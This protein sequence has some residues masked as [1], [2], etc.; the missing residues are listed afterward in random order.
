MRCSWAGDEW[1]DGLDGRRVRGWDGFRRFLLKT[2]CWRRLSLK[3]EAW[4]STPGR[5][6]DDR[7]LADPRILRSAVPGILK[8]AFVVRRTLGINNGSTSVALV[9]T[10]PKVVAS[11]ANTKSPWLGCRQLALRMTTCPGSGI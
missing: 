10:G 1:S 3:S 6:Q 11:E 2:N 7:S 5:R 9:A 4:L 8:S